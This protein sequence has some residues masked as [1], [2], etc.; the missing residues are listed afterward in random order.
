MFDLLLAWPD[1][2]D[3]AAFTPNDC[4]TQ[5]DVSAIAS[6]IRLQ[7]FLEAE[8]VLLARCAERPGADDEQLLQLLVILR[9]YQRRLD[10][11]Q[12]L[13]DQHT[14]SDAA[15]FRFAQAQLWLEQGETALLDQCVERSGWWDGEL[16]FPH[17][18]LAH[19]AYELS[20][21][22][23]DAASTLIHRFPGDPC[24]EV[25]R[26]QA[27]ILARRRDYP[28]A[29]ALLGRAAERFP[30][31]VGLQ[32]E[33]A[34]M[35]IQARSREGTIPFL[36]GMFQRHGEQSAFLD[37]LAQVQLLKREPGL[38]RRSQLLLHAAA[39]VQNLAFNPAGLVVSYE[40]TGY[41]DWMPYLHPSLMEHPVEA[42]A[43]Q[44][45]MCL[46]LSSIEASSAE[47]HVRRQV[48]RL[49][50]LPQFADHAQSGQPPRSAQFAD[51]VTPL[52]IAWLTGDLV[53]H[54]VSRFLLGFF[55][56]AEGH[57]SHRHVLVNLKNHDSESVSHRF[58][59]IAGVQQLD[60]GSLTPNSKLAAIR[61]QQAHVAID[62]SG[63]TDGNFATGFMAR[64]APVQVNYLGYFASTGIPAMDAWLGD[65]QL[66]PDPMH[67]WHQ[68]RVVRL[69]RCFIAWQPPELLPEAHCPVADRSLTGGI[70]FGSFNHNRKLSDV[71]LRLWG[72]I[73]TEI[74]DAQ[75]VLKAHQQGDTATQQLLRRRMLKQ[76]LDPERVIWLPI[77][78]TPE[79]HLKQ[80]AEMDVALDCFPNGG[81]TTTCEALWM[82]VPVIT[83]TGSTYVSRMSTAVLH[84]AGLPHLCARN[85]QHYLQLALEQASNLTW[86]RQNRAQWRLALQ[87][88]PLGDARGLMFSLEHCFLSLYRDS[89]TAAVASVR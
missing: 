27:R 4:S 42:S 12:S 83:L 44:H 22:R 17:L 25:I 40:Q 10:A 85:S 62:L 71:T 38:A 19:I 5:R 41:V 43:I 20:K 11:A 75:L 33:T 66:F 28:Q 21:E 81:C 30:Q 51:T 61:E 31:H 69:P 55:K 7:R 82:G 56:A 74:P 54:P 45:N 49:M 2:R 39:S 70:R 47:R 88:N 53:H 80:Y 73:L 79:E 60:V 63:W 14:F 67:E 89:C 52:T 1:S 87:S 8:A 29:A 3:L 68:E 9:F 6:L 32:A 72:Q 84:G 65:H 18:L 35:L 59:G 46:Y 24:M 76:G 34:S 23:D 26:F 78:A 50:A 86:L 57:L 15:F 37:S 64:M 16:E 36:R 13:L 48:Q 58:E 77:A